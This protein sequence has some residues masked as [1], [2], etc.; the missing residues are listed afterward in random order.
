M[1]LSL[2]FEPSRRECICIALQVLVYF[3]LYSLI[4]VELMASK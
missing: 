1:L 2:G 3:L 4:I